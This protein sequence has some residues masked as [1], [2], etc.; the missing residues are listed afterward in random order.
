M[1]RVETKDIG[2]VRDVYKKECG[3]N[4]GV[5]DANEEYIKLNMGIRE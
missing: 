3:C 2:E 1:V 4:S 5:E